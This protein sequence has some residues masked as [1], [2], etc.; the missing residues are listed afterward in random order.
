[1]SLLRI[2]GLIQGVQIALDD[3]QTALDDLY[4]YE[5][6]REMIREGIEKGRSVRSLSRDLGIPKSTIYDMS[7]QDFKQQECTNSES[8]H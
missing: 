3:L 8:Q 2:R 7:V 6:V 1:M 5:K 4:T